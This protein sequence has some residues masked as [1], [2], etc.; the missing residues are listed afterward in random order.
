[1]SVEQNKRIVRRIFEDDLNEP[2]PAVRARVATEIFAP[3]FHDPTNPEGL[4]HGLAGHNGTVSLFRAAFPDMR[5]EIEDMLAEGDAVV[6][7]TLMHGTH[8]GDFFGIP[9]SGRRVRVSGIHILTLR[10]GKVVLHQGVNDDLGLMR[11]LGVVAG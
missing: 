4:Q 7:R 6:V 10:D 11:Q 9:P 2:D 3:D 8:G 5:W 1:M